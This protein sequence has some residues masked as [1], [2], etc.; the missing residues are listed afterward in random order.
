VEEKKGKKEGRWE[1]K[2][3]RII[4]VRT[5]DSGSTRV[6]AKRRAAIGWGG[7]RQGM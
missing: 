6:S 3:R 1:E 7:R 4:G 2:R 5:P